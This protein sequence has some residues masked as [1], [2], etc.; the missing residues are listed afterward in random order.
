MNEVDYDAN[1]SIFGE[2][3]DHWVMNADISVEPFHQLLVERLAAFNQ[4]NDVQFHF[5]CPFQSDCADVTLNLEPDGELF[6]CYDMADSGQ[7]S[8]GNAVT[9][10]FKK[11]IWEMLQLRKAK[12]HGDCKSCKWVEACHGGCMSEAIH[13]TGSPFGKTPHCGLWQ[14]IF[15]KLMMQ[16]I[17][18]VLVL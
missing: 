12:L 9:G 2:I 14:T 15:K 4:S 3:F 17:I 5:G 18:T 7:Y 8:L 1:S 16:S 13:Y 6:I 11:D 10:E